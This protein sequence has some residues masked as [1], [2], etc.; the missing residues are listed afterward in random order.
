[1]EQTSRSGLLGNGCVG[2]SHTEAAGLVRATGVV[3]FRGTICNFG[4]LDEEK[5]DEAVMVGVGEG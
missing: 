4:G 5:R 3:W 1:M 2:F